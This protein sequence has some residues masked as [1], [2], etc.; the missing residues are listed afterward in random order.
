MHCGRICECFVAVVFRVFCR[1]MIPETGLPTL[2]SIDQCG[3]SA[4]DIQ[5]LTTGLLSGNRDVTSIQQQQGHAV[6]TTVEDP[7]CVCVQWP[8]VPGL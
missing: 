1:L 5:Q 4:T 8:I 2:I 7:M 6:K 3:L